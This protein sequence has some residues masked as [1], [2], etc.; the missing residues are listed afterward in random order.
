M[1]KIPVT[2]LSWF[3][4]AW[5]TT[6]LNNILKQR[7]NKKVALIVNDMWEINV[8]ANLVKNWNSLSKTEE[9]LVEM[10]NWCVCCTLRED[11]LIEVEKL[12][13]EWKYDALIIESTWIAEPVPVA[14]TF[15]YIDE[16][17][18]IDLTKW[19]YIDTMVTVVD[20]YN[21]LDQF[22]SDK[23]LNEIKMWV[24]ENDIRPLVNLIVEQIEFCNIIILNKV[25]LVTK[26]E[27]N[28]IKWIIRWLQADAKIIETVNS[29]VDIKEIIDTWLFDY[30]N[31]SLSPLWVKE[32]ES[33]WHH[34][35]ISETDE[36]WISS[37]I[38]K[39]DRPFHPE[40]FLEIVSKTWPWVIRSKWVMWFAS[41]ND[42]A[43]NWSLAWGSVRLDALGKW[44]ASFSKEERDLYNPIESLAYEKE[45]WN[46]K[47]WDRVNE[48][49][50][51]WVKMDNEEIKKLL[52]YAILT[53]EE[54]EK[55]E[56]WINFKDNLPSWDII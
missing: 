23:T 39:K 28:Y 5:K 24:D 54:M 53:D 56:S 3:L 14:Q 48:F 22:S 10:S 34:C 7:W 32:L 43:W 6:L 37:F 51:I 50:V 52:D 49:V 41:R 17:T 45:H 31:A 12:A 9:K 8:D 42:I 2:V 18:W 40:R 25:D 1:K 38:Y 36:Y 11:L 35:H 55:P 20:A 21:F 16:E 15:S 4:G 13:R 46:K 29:E 27:L 26:E 30:D 47:F 44:M 19:A 33:G